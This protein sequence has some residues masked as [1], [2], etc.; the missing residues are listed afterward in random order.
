[1]PREGSLEWR[2]P[3]E[4]Q[5]PADY[6]ALREKATKGETVSASMVDVGAFD[7]WVTSFREEY[8]AGSCFFTATMQIKERGVR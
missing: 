8:D 7:F 2:W 3:R 4:Q 1:M 5:P 6:T